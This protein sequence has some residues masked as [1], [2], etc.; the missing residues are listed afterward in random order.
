ME[1]T[2]NIEHKF[3]LSK[4]G[5]KMETASLS[6]LNVQKRDHLLRLSTMKA[7][8]GTRN[9][10]ELPS[11]QINSVGRI[12]ESLM[13]LPSR[14]VLLGMADDRR[15]VLLD[16]LDCSAGSSLV[17]SD[18]GYGKTHQLQV[19]LDSA[20][21]IKLAN[22][23]GVVVI[24]PDPWEWQ[25]QLQAYE[26]KPVSIECLGWQEPQ[27]IKVIKHLTAMTQDRLVDQRQSKDFILILDEV[28]N[29]KYLD[30]ESQVS[31]NFLY[32]SGPQA[33]IW[34]FAS[35]SADR[36]QPDRDM[37]DLFKTW[38]FGHI[39]SLPGIFIQERS[40]SILV[41]NEPGQFSVKMEGKWFSYRLPM[42]GR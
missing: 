2:Y 14:A 15:P 36:E 27:T 39:R 26:K 38:V 6:V 16:L 32:T 8:K 3:Y 21:A 37:M 35:L 9:A 25:Y 40:D 17:I 33:R 31:L 22:K 23:M 41:D 20:V 24:S 12:I 18:S 5:A 28:S 11:R 7:I 10:R 19:I 42:I 4:T 34:P 30:E 29:M 1:Y 13:D